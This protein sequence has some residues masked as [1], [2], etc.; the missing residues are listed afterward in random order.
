[1]FLLFSVESSFPFGHGGFGWS[2]PAAT[3]GSRAHVL[4]DC[5]ELIE[6]GRTV[7]RICFGG[8]CD[9]GGGAGSAGAAH[10]GDLARRLCEAL[11][12]FDVCGGQA[13]SL[14]RGQPPSSGLLQTLGAL[15]SLSTTKS[16]KMGPV[17]FNPHDNHFGSPWASCC[18]ALWNMAWPLLTVAWI[19]FNCLISEFRSAVSA[20][21]CL[22]CSTICDLA[23]ASFASVAVFF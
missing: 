10:R 23:S 22:L 13:R 2:L 12:G 6:W 15:P 4:S 18:N 1:M 14:R 5:G 19:V 17:D 20:C 7:S 16:R 3:F 21:I 8:R 11:D 9:H